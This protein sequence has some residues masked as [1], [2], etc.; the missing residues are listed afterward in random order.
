M[1]RFDPTLDDD[2]RITSHVKD[3]GLSFY[4]FI[5]LNHI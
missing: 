3:Y 5:Y 1:T 2:Q 4:L